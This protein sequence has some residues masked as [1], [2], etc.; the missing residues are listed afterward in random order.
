MG[1]KDKLNETINK[2]KD[3]ISSATGGKFQESV[4]KAKKMAGSINKENLQDSIDK[5]KSMASSVNKESVQDALGKA[6]D[7]ASSLNKESLTNATNKLRDIASSPDQL[8]KYASKKYI[9]WASAI[10]AILFIGYLFFGGDSSEIKMVKNSPC[11]MDKSITIGKM[12]D[13]YSYVSNPE[14]EV[15]KNNRGQKVVQFKAKCKSNIPTSMTRFG[16]L[17]MYKDEFIKF[18]SKEDFDLYL[19][20]QYSIDADGKGGKLT[21]AGFEYLGEVATSYPATMQNVLNNVLKDSPAASSVLLTNPAAKKL[22]YLVYKFTL[23]QL[24]SDQRKIITKLEPSKDTNAYQALQGLA[25]PLVVYQFSKPDFDN[26]KNEISFDVEEEVTNIPN[27]GG[28]S[29]CQLLSDTKYANTSFKVLQKDSFS[30]MLRWRKNGKDDLN[31]ASVVFINPKTDEVQFGINISFGEPIE[32][33][34]QG[35]LFSGNLERKLFD[36]TEF[37]KQ[38]N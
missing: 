30:A 3:T 36:T 19:L 17:N 8:K 16:Q 7:M 32:M 38:E 2:A 25:Y 27:P 15:L 33:D 18:L 24:T 6:K 23:G 14:W 10:V 35:V 21:Y 9:G 20:V 31:G 13:S 5:A 34:I 11:P 12:L 28:Y 29:D 1:F 26:S 22:A 4:D 37:A